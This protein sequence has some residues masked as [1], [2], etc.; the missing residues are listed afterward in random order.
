MA[1][2]SQVLEAKKINPNAISG[3]MYPTLTEKRKKEMRS[4]DFLLVSS[5]E[6]RD[7][8]LE[9]NKDIFIYYSF[10][11]IKE[12]EKE[13]KDKE[14]IV[15]GYHGNKVHLECM[16]DVSQAL[17]QLSDK[18]KIELWAIYNI[19]KLGEWKRNLPK[20]CPVKHI[21]WSEDNYYQYLSQ[22]DIGIMPAKTSIN[23]GWGK[24]ITRVGSGFFNNWPRYS[25][26]DYLLR[27]KYS[28]N[29]GRAYIFSQF[30]IPVVADFLPSCAQIIQD[31]ESGYLVWSKEGWHNALEKLIT[32]P[33]LRNQ[34]SRNLK[35]FIDNNYSPD[36]NFQ[37]FLEFIKKIK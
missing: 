14:K 20:K 24:L 8:L 33:D 7:L 15:I 31:G 22:S 29:P 4:A 11:E 6:H 23:L 21:Q 34:M 9:Y 35:N 18:Y 25:K 37:K 13:H 2:D 3:I 12:I 36:L 1:P 26:Y 16:S 27:F 17:D 30:H 10:P 5:L 32:S 19:N 28:S